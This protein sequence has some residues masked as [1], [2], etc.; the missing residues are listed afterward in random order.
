MVSQAKA[1]VQNADLKI[2]IRNRR[3]PF[4]YN[5]SKPLAL[6]KESSKHFIIKQDYL[7]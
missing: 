5:E 7:A 2:K 1:A 4:I 6:Y 3:Q